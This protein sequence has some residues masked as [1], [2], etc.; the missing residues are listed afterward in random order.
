MSFV[1]LCNRCLKPIDGEMA[2][3]DKGLYFHQRCWI[4]EVKQND[5]HYDAREHGA[6]DFALPSNQGKATLHR[7]RR[8]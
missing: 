8:R 6:Y 3:L 4:L 5:N 7:V 1:Y 2:V